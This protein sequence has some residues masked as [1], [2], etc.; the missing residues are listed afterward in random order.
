MS[1]PVKVID[2]FC[3]CGGFSEGARQAGAVVS[4]G[5]DNDPD[6][7]EIHAL[8]H[9]HVTHIC[10]TLPAIIPAVERG[11]R[12]GAHLHASPSCQ[13]LSQAN[14]MV[15]EDQASDAAAVVEW[16]LDT[17]ARLRPLTWSFEQVS[18]PATMP[19]RM[20]R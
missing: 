16:Y 17:V 19:M 1:V 5:V 7:L 8:N 10:T 6:A 2:L 12:S 18:T 13:K 14:R 9:P 11:V 4:I 15:T 3:G 20:I